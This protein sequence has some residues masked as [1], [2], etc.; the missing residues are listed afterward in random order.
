MITLSKSVGDSF[1]KSGELPTAACYAIRCFIVD[2]NPG[3]CNSLAFWTN[4]PF[5]EF[6]EILCSP[7]QPSAIH[8]HFGQTCLFTNSPNISTTVRGSKFQ[9]IREKA[10]LSKMGV[11][12]RRLLQTKILDGRTNVWERSFEAPFKWVST[13]FHVLYSVLIFLY[14]TYK[15]MACYSPFDHFLSRR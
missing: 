15:S 13:R 9:G 7:N 11:S 10:G 5:H 2:A 6:P 12:C 3:V 14:K 4:L 8:P 1:Q